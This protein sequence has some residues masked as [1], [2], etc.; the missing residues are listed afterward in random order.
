[1]RRRILATVLA[2]KIFHTDPWQPNF[3]LKQIL[4]GMLI[5]S[6]MNGLDQNIM[7]L[8]LSCRK[9]EDAQKNMFTLAFVM[10]AVNFV[11]VALG[12]LVQEYYRTRGLALPLNAAGA[13]A[14]DQTLS[15][16]T[17]NGLGRPAAMMFI[18]GLSAATFS[19]AGTILPA[20]A[21][22]IEIDLL[23]TRLRNRIPVR[24]VHALAAVLILGL[25]LFIH[26]TGTKSI[27]DL[28]LRWSGYTYGPLIGLYGIGIFTRTEI[29]HR[30]VPYFCLASIAIT[31]WI[32]ASSPRWWSGY[33]LG[34]ELIAINAVIFLALAFGL[35]RL[36]KE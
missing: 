6:S 34:V 2:P 14:Y 22:S 4:G 35:G 21:S 20:I 24:L 32:D 11:F 16:L 27:I 29:D 7:Q 15:F 1:M 28:V 3:F 10:V 25:I 5:T 23:P 36:K 13:P 26:S 19:S 12:A 30:R 8:N 9:L 31:A 33:R 17:L 18:I